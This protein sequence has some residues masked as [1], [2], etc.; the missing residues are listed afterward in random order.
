MAAARLDRLAAVRDL[1]RSSEVRTQAQVVE[2][3]R[4]QGFDV[5]QATVSR[6]IADLGLRKGA[7]G[8]YVLESE[9]RLQALV[10]AA[11]REVRRALNQVVVITDPGSASSVAAALDGAAP[12]GIIGS[13]AGDDTVL[14]IAADEA[15][16][17]RFQEGMQGLL[18]VR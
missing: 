15:A 18:S 5:T 2:A 13:I 11:V 4:D 1:V 9:Q 14:V 12:Q 3:L 16:A 10:T 8:A 6:D 17:K 7:S